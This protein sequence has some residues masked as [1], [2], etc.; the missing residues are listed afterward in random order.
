MHNIFL[1]LTGPAYRLFE[2]YCPASRPGSGIMA[3]RQGRCVMGSFLEW[4]I[5]QRSGVAIGLAVIL[6]A[7]TLI[8]RYG[9]N[10]WWPWGIGMAVVLG[11]VGLFAGKSE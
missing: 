1:Q 4:L 11:V 10:L 3:L 6:F 8:L 7:F 5:E 9:F 2:V